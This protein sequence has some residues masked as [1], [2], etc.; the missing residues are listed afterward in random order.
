MEGIYCYIDIKTNDIVYVGQDNLINKHRRRRQHLQKGRYNDQPINRVL[1]NNPNRYRYKVLRK[2][3]FSKEQLNK[4]ER[5]CIAKFNPS[6]NFTIGG[7]CR[8]P[9]KL[10]EDH[11]KKISESLKGEKHPMYGKHLSNAQKQRLSELNK[12]H[13]NSA[14]KYTLWD[15][16][17]TRFDK[18]QCTKI[19]PLRK[20]FS[21]KYQGKRVCI[22]HFNEFVSCEIIHG[23]VMEAIQ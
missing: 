21:Y 3:H 2:G 4:M 11:R 6:F 17:C 16:E 9:K 10:S 15:I 8:P 22:G 5:D 23:F 19:N 12:G 18:K 7:E 1:Q 20:S 13:N 14:A